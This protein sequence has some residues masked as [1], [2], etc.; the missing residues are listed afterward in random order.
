MLTFN[1]DTHE[2]FWDGDIV[3]Y[4][5]TG[6][7][8]AAGLI[9]GTYYTEYSRTR[10][11]YVHEATQFLDE[12]C[13]D[14]DSIDQAI[15]PYVMAYERF[16]TESKFVPEHIE[17]RVYCPAYQ[18]AGTLDRTGDLN[19]QDILLDIKTSEGSPKAWWGPQLSGYNLAMGLSLP[20]F[21][22]QLKR[23]ST[24]KLTEFKDPND[25]QIFLAANLLVRWK[26]SKGY[27]NA[28]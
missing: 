12:G 14:W 17:K 9:G 6:I 26:D 4:S 21:S 25:N 11:S 19:G 28:E 5:V 2:Y 10:G 23:D 13:L 20:R 22:L 8:K 7:L 27:K 3:P 15:E 16:K 1:E 24:Y 18:Y